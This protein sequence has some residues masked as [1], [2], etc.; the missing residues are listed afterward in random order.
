MIVQIPKNIDDS[1]AKIFLGLSFGKGISVMGM[2]A[3]LILWI[4]TGRTL[5]TVLLVAILTFIGFLGFFEYQGMNGITFLLTLV[6]HFFTGT[7]YQFEKL[8]SST[9]LPKKEAKKLNKKILKQEQK[10]KKKG[11]AYVEHVTFSKSKKRKG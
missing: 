4:A 11:L 3:V 7:S 9:A 10:A 5:P 1:K 2:A 8:F 6:K